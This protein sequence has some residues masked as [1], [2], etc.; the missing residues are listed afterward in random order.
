[1]LGNKAG[2][3]DPRRGAKPPQVALLRGYGTAWQA[4][5]DDPHQGE[6]GIVVG[7]AAWF[8]WLDAPSTQ[9]FGY[10]VYDARA[11]YIVGFMTVRKERRARGGTYWVAYRR[12]RGQVRKVYLGRSVKLTHQ[13]LEQQAQ[14]FLAVDTR[15]APG[16]GTDGDSE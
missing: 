4:V 3:R 9:S 12:T 11:G 15:A 7:S 5:L 2:A 14:A 13:T 8:A 1:M 10:P 6:N 16:P